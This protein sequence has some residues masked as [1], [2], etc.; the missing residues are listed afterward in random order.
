MSPS[1][2]RMTKQLFCQIIITQFKFFRSCVDLQFR[3][4][5]VLDGKECPGDSGWY[6]AG[7]CPQSPSSAYIQQC[8]IHE[9]NSGHRW[10]LGRCWQGMG[11]ITQYHWAT[12]GSLRCQTPQCAAICPPSAASERIHRVLWQQTLPHG[13][14][15]AETHRVLRQELME[16]WRRPEKGIFFDQQHLTEWLFSSVKQRLHCIRRIQLHCKTNYQQYN[17]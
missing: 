17:S 16:H 3:F 11:C 9:E 13:T 6:T 8:R 12:A 1:L 5:S 4:H 10:D 14:H 7:V 2:C 15:Q